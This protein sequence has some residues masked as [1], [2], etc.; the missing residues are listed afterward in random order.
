MLHLSGRGAMRGIV[1]G[2]INEQ[3]RRALQVLLTGDAELRLT[4]FD[5]FVP[6]WEAS[7]EITVAPATDC[8]NDGTRETVD[9]TSING[10][11]A[12]SS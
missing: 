2:G 9:D 8:E 5:D 11:E 4:G 6:I 10:L 12:N 3:R 7:G 1:S